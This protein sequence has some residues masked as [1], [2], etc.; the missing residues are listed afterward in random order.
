MKLRICKVI[1]ENHDTR[2]LYFADDEDGG[3]AFDYI[4]GQYLTFRFD[5]LAG[6]PLARSYTMSSSPCES[7][8]V[9]VTVKEVSKG[10]VSEY[11]CRN[12]KEGDVLRARGPIGKFCYFAETDAPHL[13]MVAAGSG[14]TPFTS[15]LREYAPHLGKKGAP[16]RMTLLVSYRSTHDL[17]NWEDL[18]AVSKIPGVEIVTTLSRENAN[19]KGFLFGRINE[20]MLKKVFLHSL[21]NT[22]FM[23][24][25]PKEMM[26]LTTHFLS[27]HHVPRERIKVESYEST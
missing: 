3:R 27:T 14:V 1:Q 9:A 22:T 20:E 8:Y 10:I 21:E 12:T 13:A 5:D 26:N 11:L 18:K 17:V 15:M 23:T 24:C 4:P 16:Q 6:K 25:G 2:T 19:D 7:D